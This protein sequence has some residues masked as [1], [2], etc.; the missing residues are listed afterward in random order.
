MTTFLWL[1]GLERKLQELLSSTNATQK[2]NRQHVHNI[3][4]R[5]NHIQRQRQSY[6]KNMEKVLNL[7]EEIKGK[8]DQAKDNLRLAVRLQ[9]HII[10]PAE[11]R[12]CRWRDEDAGP[13]DEGVLSS[14]CSQDIPAGDAAEASQFSALLQA[15][16]RLADK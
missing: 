2:A 14:H 13:D 11:A 9:N 16:A 3:A 1:T 15:A 10:Q 6:S 12:P 4:T 5:E 8:L 7:M